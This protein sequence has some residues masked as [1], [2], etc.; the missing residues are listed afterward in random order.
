MNILNHVRDQYKIYNKRIRMKR[1][2]YCIRVISLENGNARFFTMTERILLL[3][4]TF[5]NK[6]HRFLS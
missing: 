4:I 5:R 2:I 3:Q 6:T 1:A